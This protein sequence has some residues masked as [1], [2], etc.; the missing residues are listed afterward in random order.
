MH[1]KQ[2]KICSVQ[3]NFAAFDSTFEVDTPFCS[4]YT[5]DLSER[6]QTKAEDDKTN[7]LEYQVNI[8]GWDSPN[9]KLYFLSLWQ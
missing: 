9:L 3:I 6:N 2:K 7:Q 1:L 4:S 8:L 5:Y